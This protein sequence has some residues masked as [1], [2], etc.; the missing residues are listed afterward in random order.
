MVSQGLPDRAVHPLSGSPALAD[1]LRSLG[2]A[3]AT[4]R[5]LELV[6]TLETGGP[7][8]V[9]FDPDAAY[10]YRAEFLNLRHPLVRAVGAFYGEHPDRFHKGGYAR[11]P[12]DR[13]AGQWIFF[14]FLLSATGLVP[15]RTLYPVA[16]DVATGTVDPGVGEEILA[17]LSGPDPQRI[18]E[19]EIPFLD[20]DAARSV[21]VPWGGGV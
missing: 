16:Y 21:G 12:S 6:T 18:R 2:R 13:E 8:A 1:L 15:A 3:F 19:D 9:T 4:E 10:E 14:L 20:P 7:V 17:H 5:F 11:I